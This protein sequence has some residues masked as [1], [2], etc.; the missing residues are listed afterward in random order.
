MYGKER[1]RKGV[2]WIFLAQESF[3]WWHLRMWERNFG[4]HKMMGIDYMRNYFS[5]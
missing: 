4:V 5:V 3:P 2:D 1:G